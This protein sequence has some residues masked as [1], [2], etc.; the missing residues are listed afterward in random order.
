MPEFSGVFSDWWWIRPL[1]QG[2]LKT[3]PTLEGLQQYE[4]VVMGDLY[5]YR[6]D[7]DKLR[8]FHFVDVFLVE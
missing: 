7:T 4:R 8:I 6:N 2:N 5:R 3:S 1:L